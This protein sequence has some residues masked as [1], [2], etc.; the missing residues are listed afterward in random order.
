MADTKISDLTEKTVPVADDLFVLVDSEDDPITNKKIKWSNV[1]KG[2]TATYILAASDAPANIKAQADATCD[3]V[4]DEE[5]IATAIAS[6]GEIKLSSGHFYTSGAGIDITIGNFSLVGSGEST[7]IDASTQ[8]ASSEVFHVHGAI[9]AVTGTLAA[10]AIVG[11]TSITI[12][13]GEGAS[14]AAND[15]IRI[16]SNALF[17]G[18]EK[19]AELAQILS[20]AGDVLTLYSPLYD[21]YNTADTATIEKLTCYSNITLKDFQIIAENTDDIRGILA[22]YAVNLRVENITFVD[23]SMRCVSLANV[24][25]PL[26]TDCTFINC[27]DN[28]GNCVS[29]ADDSRDGRVVN[30][31][32]KQCRQAVAWCN[33][34]TQGIE[35]NFVIANNVVTDSVVATDDAFEGYSDSENFLVIG[36]V[37][38]NQGLARIDGKKM[39]VI[40]NTVTDPS[41]NSAVTFASTAIYCTLQDNHIYGGGE[42]NGLVQVVAGLST[43]YGNLIENNW[44]YATSDIAL[45][46]KSGGITVRGNYIR[47]DGATSRAIYVLQT[48]SSAAMESITIDSNEV[49][50]PTAVAVRGGIDIYT[51][52]TSAINIVQINDNYIHDCLYGVYIHQNS[53]GRI[54]QVQCNNNKIETC[55]TGISIA[56]SDNV[57]ICNNDIYNCTTPVSLSNNTKVL[58]NN[59]LGYIASGEVRTASGTLT[60]GVANAIAFAWHNPE[61]QDILIKKV[62]IEV[63]TGGGTAGSH[64][65]VGIADDATGTNRG[66]EFFNDIDLNL[67]AILDSTL[68]ASGGTQTVWVFCQDSASATD[69]WIVGQ[70]LDA[71]AASLVGSYYIEYVGK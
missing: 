49:T 68:A 67:T 48:S 69:G 45:Y 6:G 66:T 29:I 11:A 7:I 64:L 53:T 47:T 35:R 2:R 5:D 26:I 21:T 28:A 32:F 50:N 18:G 27:N 1:A 44:I 25:Y 61:A 63:T 10:N 23:C 36:N 15:Y 41:L 38:T 33:S 52:G 70:I 22:E 4:N 34:G 9:T 46:I 51:T 54:T 17:N 8:T 12:G 3:G 20:I 37:V 39:S 40:G 42:S 31:Y 60:A 59:T 19:I 56:A 13:S 30:N 43:S 57:Q 71:D 62:V 24:L 14:F 16:K 65:D 55:G 58:I